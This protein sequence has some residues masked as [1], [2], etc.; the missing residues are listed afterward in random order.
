MKFAMVP[1]VFFVA[2]SPASG[3]ITNQPFHESVRC[4]F[5]T[6]LERDS[7]QSVATKELTPAFGGGF[8][9]F[10]IHSGFGIS[11]GI[12]S[13]SKKGLKIYRVCARSEHGYIC[14]EKSLSI[15]SVPDESSEVHC[16]MHQDQ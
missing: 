2:V 12:D 14:G 9:D 5:D 8:L 4:V 16:E 3:K 15:Y 7:E 10:G 6:A 11:V 1:L 13:D